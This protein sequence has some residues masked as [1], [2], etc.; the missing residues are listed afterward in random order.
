MVAKN[1][2][3]KKKPKLV[4]FIGFCFFGVKSGFSKKIQLDGFR[5]FY[6]FSVIKMKTTRQMIFT[7]NK[8]KIL[9]F[10]C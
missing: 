8:Y 5:D 3:F 7:S 9:Q 2:L 1:G 10:Y 4:G 6:G